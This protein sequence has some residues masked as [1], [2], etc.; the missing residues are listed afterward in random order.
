MSLTR[1]QIREELEGVLGEAKRGMSPAVWQHV[2]PGGTE[3]KKNEKIDQAKKPPTGK[4][5][6]VRP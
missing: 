5:I 3:D 2:K 4:R 1:K 6:F